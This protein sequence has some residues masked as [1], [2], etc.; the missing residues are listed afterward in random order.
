MP[1]MQEREVGSHGGSR[2]IGKAYAELF[3]FPPK[4]YH[5]LWEKNKEI[6]DEM[7]ETFP[8]KE[9]REHGAVDLVEAWFERY[10]SE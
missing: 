9:L 6:L 3:W 2:M 4:K 1:E 8:M 10:L 5:P 7:R